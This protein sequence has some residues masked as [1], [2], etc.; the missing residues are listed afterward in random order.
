MLGDFV[1][2]ISG[3]AGLDRIDQGN[4]LVD[5]GAFGARG[6]IGRLGG[7]LAHVHA[8]ADDAI[9]FVAT[10]VAV[11]SGVLNALGWA[12]VAVYLFFAVGSGYLLNP[13]RVTA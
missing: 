12:I 2:Q 13:K 4:L 8:D 10:L 5:E 7:G 1:E 9:G 11:L 3:E 6:Q